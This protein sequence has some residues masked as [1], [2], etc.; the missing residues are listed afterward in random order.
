M[1]L[2]P[3]PHILLKDLPSTGMAHVCEHFQSCHSLLSTFPTCPLAASTTRRKGRLTR[4]QGL[5]DLIGLVGVLE[6]ESV[7][8]TLSA[9]LELDILALC[10]FLQAGTYREENRTL[11]S[12]RLI[13][14]FYFYSIVLRTGEGCMGVFFNERSQYGRV[15]H[16]WH[17][18]CERSRGIA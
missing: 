10:G 7:E 13:I 6:L 5:L 11:V 18:S 4:R 16:L 12:K 8:E 2:P 3:H 15:A 17:P 1:K 9:E 14:S